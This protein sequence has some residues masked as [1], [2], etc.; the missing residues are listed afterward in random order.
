[1]SQIAAISSACRLELVYV[2][3]M[4][5]ATCSLIRTVEKAQTCAYTQSTHRRTCQ[6]ETA[7][8]FASLGDSAA[9][10]ISTRCPAGNAPTLTI[11]NCL[12]SVIDDIVDIADNGVDFG[13][14]KVSAAVSWSPAGVTAEVTTL[15]MSLAASALSGKEDN[16]R[17]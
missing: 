8:L 4:L 15:Y 5:G 17:R 10:R 12:L 1:M 14:G 13:V 7:A 3:L 6:Y 2:H 11:G 9:A 16:R